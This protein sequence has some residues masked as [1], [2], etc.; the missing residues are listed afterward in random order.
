MLSVLERKERIVEAEIN[1]LEYQEANREPWGSGGCIVWAV[2]F[3][4]H[5]AGLQRLAVGVPG[6]QPRVAVARRHSGV[7]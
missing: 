2:E 5:R 6:G 7:D 1:I 4:V 3:A